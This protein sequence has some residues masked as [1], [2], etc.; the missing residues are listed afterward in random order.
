MSEKYNA[1]KKAV[2]YAQQKPE[3]LAGYLADAIADVASSVAIN[4]ADSI[5]T[6]AGG[7][8]VTS[9]YTAKVF[10]QYGDEMSGQTI[11][12]ALKSAVTGVSIDSSTGVVTVANTVTAK[13][14]TITATSSGKVAEKTITLLVPE[15]ITITGDASIEVPEG[16][17][18]NTADYTAKVFDQNGDEFTSPTVTFA[19]KA[20]VTGVSVSG[21]TVSVAKTAVAE[22]FTL[23]ATCGG[24]SEEKEVALTSA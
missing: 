16:D 15:E 24:A 11:T 21:N 14:C 19:L 12:F 5:K 2:F 17:T 22:G 8:S 23:V 10:S 1:L 4:G 3:M 18:A 13:S 9:T 7:S 6:P 20:E